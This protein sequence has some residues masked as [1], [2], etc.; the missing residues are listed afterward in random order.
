MANGVYKERKLLREAL[1][2]CFT[3][4]DLKEVI[5]N[6]IEIATNKKYKPSERIKASQTILDYTTGKPKQE[7]DPKALDEM[8]EF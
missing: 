8:F 1:L 3:S 4:D 6:L 7:T 5:Q 2:T